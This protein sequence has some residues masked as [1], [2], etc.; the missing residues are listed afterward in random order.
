MTLL[1]VETG[2]FFGQL[3]GSDVDLLACSASLS[4]PRFFARAA[5]A[6]AAVGADVECA[7]D[8]T[9][10]LIRFQACHEWK[11]VA[12]V[13]ILVIQWSIAPKSCRHFLGKAKDGRQVE[14]QFMELSAEHILQLRDSHTAVDA[15]SH[16]FE[17][18]EAQLFVPKESMQAPGIPGEMYGNAE[19]ALV[20]H[21]V[22]EVYS[23][24]L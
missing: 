17:A 13:V 15:E 6:L 16:A 12:L 4:Q 24:Q 20:G 14:V 3:Q 10:P 7:S 9:V 11:K 2:P 5:E 1:G 21:F 18:L 22:S 23:L 8:A 19:G